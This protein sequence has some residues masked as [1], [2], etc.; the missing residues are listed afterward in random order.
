MTDLSLQDKLEIAVMDKNRQKILRLVSLGASPDMPNEW[1]M[2]PLLLAVEHELFESV[3]ALIDAGANVNAQNPKGV[4]PLLW[5]VDASVDYTQQRGGKPNDAPTEIIELLLGHGADITLHD[6]RGGT[7]LDR[8][9]WSPK[10]TD[11]LLSKG[12]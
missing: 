6:S 7:P 8:A 3:K 12:I 1:D 2:S 11:L 10:I 4:T 5:A 9:S